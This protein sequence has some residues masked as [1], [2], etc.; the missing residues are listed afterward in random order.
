MEIPAYV[1]HSNWD[2]I[3]GG[4]CDALADSLNIEVTGIL[5]PQTGLGR[6]GIIKNGPMSL[7]EFANNVSLVLKLNHLKI[8]NNDMLY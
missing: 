3:K 1:I 8:V 7:T 4:A 6:I 2:I 5:D